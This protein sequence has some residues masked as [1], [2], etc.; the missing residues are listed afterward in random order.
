MPNETVDRF[1]ITL[2]VIV[3][4]CRADDVPVLEWWGQFFAHRATIEATYAAQTRGEAMMLVAEVAGYPSG[5][6][7]IDLRH[8]YDTR[9]GGI[10]AVRVF[11]LL[12]GRGIGTHLIDAAEQ[13]LRDALFTAAEL[14]VEKDNTGARRFY[15]RRGYQVIGDLQGAYTYCPPGGEP[16]DEPMNQWVMRKELWESADVSSND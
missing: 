13:Y 9:V 5:Q 14:T 10:W 2:D 11:P 6:A 15:E 16:V 1:N 12:Q 7:W 3:R 4:Q 8:R